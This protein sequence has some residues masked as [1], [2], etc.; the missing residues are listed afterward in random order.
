MKKRKYKEV[1]NIDFETYN[2][3]DYWGYEDN[4]YK[5][6]IQQMSINA[7]RHDILKSLNYDFSTNEDSVSTKRK[8]NRELFIKAC[9]K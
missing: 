9:K 2:Q 5:E 6:D 8:Q 7:I 1:Y 3:I 4:K